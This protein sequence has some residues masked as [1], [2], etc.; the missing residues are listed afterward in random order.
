MYDDAAININTVPIPSPNINWEEQYQIKNENNLMQTEDHLEEQKQIKIKNENDLMQIEDYLEQNNKAIETL[1]NITKYNSNSNYSIEQIEKIEQIL[2]SSDELRKKLKNIPDWQFFQN[3]MTQFAMKHK[4]IDFYD[5]FASSNTAH[6]FMHLKTLLFCY[7][8]IIIRYFSDDN[9]LPELFKNSINEIIDP[10]KMRVSNDI[11]VLK[12]YY[13]KILNIIDEV[14]SSD[15]VKNILDEKIFEYVKTVAKEQLNAFLNNYSQNAANHN[16]FFEILTWNESFVSKYNLATYQKDYDDIKEFIDVYKSI[17]LTDKT[18]ILDVL[19]MKDDIIKLHT[20]LLNINKNVFFLNLKKIPENVNIIFECLETFI[21]IDGK[22][23]ELQKNIADLQST[24]FQTSQEV[25]ETRRMID[26]YVNNIETKSIKIQEILKTLNMEKYDT[27]EWFN[28]MKRVFENNVANLKLPLHYNLFEILLQ[29]NMFASKHLF[30]PNNENTRFM[31]VSEILFDFRQIIGEQNVKYNTML[32]DI[33]TGFVYDIFNDDSGIQHFVILLIDQQYYKYTLNSKTL[34]YENPIKVTPTRSDSKISIVE[35]IV[36]AEE[37][38]NRAMEYNKQFQNLCYQKKEQDRI[39]LRNVIFIKNACQ[40][41]ELTLGLVFHNNA[42]EVVSVLWCD[43]IKPINMTLNQNAL[44]SWGVNINDTINNKEHLDYELHINR[45]T[46]KKYSSN[47]MAR[48]ITAIFINIMSIT[49]ICDKPV[50][51]I[52]SEAINPISVWLLVYHFKWKMLPIKSLEDIEYLTSWG[53]L[54]PN[55]I[56][57]E[58]FFQNQWADK[59]INEYNKEQFR[60]ELTRQFQRTY[61]ER[62]TNAKIFVESLMDEQ[63]LQ[64]AKEIEDAYFNENRE[65]FCDLLKTGDDFYNITSFEDVSGVRYEETKIDES[66]VVGGRRWKQKSKKC[67]KTKVT[68]A[69]KQR[70]SKKQK[71]SK[72]RKHKSIKHKL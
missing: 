8:H 51:R 68:K 43:N 41:P 27:K 13:V 1:N 5:I 61:G 53:N 7:E 49:R 12:S 18:T 48:I 55:L 62:Q 47:G 21:Q 11:T 19:D 38:Y 15:F 45:F 37:I 64:R 9:T 39:H 24:H 28:Q 34:F 54:D 4:R 57:L 14:G 58:D 66:D 71:K 17:T 20:L 30:K 59:D 26:D 63:D 44:E 40:N 69:K 31:I 36:N 16:L 33:K 70:T 32:K 3:Y 72:T 25:V 65:Q 2:G 67:L 23:K 10:Q 52:L 35:N 60:D 6:F 46:P 22:I 56:N 29:F 42:A 50:K